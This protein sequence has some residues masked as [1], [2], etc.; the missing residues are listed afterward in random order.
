MILLGRFAST[1][2]ACL[3]AAAPQV[4][5]PAMLG[6]LTSGAAAA[7]GLSAAATRGANRNS[8]PPITTLVPSASAPR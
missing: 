7:T 4:V 2:T 8:M 6:V 1:V 3:G 5:Q